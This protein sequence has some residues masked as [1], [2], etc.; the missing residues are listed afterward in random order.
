MRF[1]GWTGSCGE[2]LEKFVAP[3]TTQG[4]AHGCHRWCCVSWGLRVEPPVLS[5]PSGTNSGENH[6]PTFHKAEGTGWKVKAQML[7]G[8]RRPDQIG[9][10]APALPE[11]AGDSGTW[12]SLPQPSSLSLEP[13][14]LGPALLLPTSAEGAGWE[15]PQGPAMARGPGVPVQAAGRREAFQ[16]GPASSHP[17]AFPPLN[18]AASKMPTRPGLPQSIDFLLPL[19]PGDETQAHSY[20]VICI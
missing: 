15:V 10:W 1:V 7:G 18:P 8:P 3:G 16:A 2:R 9:I 5:E 4:K 20:Q 14:E 13:G 12:L 11:L 19:L 17:Q 6:C